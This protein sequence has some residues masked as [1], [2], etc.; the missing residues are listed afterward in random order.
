MLNKLFSLNKQ[1]SSLWLGRSIF[2]GLVLFL[3]ATMISCNTDDDSDDGDGGTTP[4]VWTLIS[5]YYYD[6]NA[7]GQLSME[8]D[9]NNANNARDDGDVTWE[10]EYDADGLRTGY[11]MYEGA[12]LDEDGI[13][14][15]F[16]DSNDCNYRLE[17][18]TPQGTNLQ[19]WTYEVDSN[20]LRTSYRYEGNDTE[21]TG[22]YL[23]DENDNVIE[24]RLGNGD[25][26]EYTLDDDGER[27]RYD[28]YQDD[29][30]YRYGIYYYSNGQLDELRNYE[31]R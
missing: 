6:Y 30:L 28:F 18:E 21:E 1:Y 10:Y 12:D 13:G 8:T 4:G 26:W 7:Q 9:D 22:T 19:V 5:V 17:E 11:L 16:Y 14:T 27:L 3:A 24:L 31:Q 23:R 20:C 2:L 15:Y 29:A 25:Y